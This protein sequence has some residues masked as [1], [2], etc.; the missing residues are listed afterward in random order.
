L[1]STDLKAPRHVLFSIPLLPRS[2]W[3]QVSS[4]AYVFSHNVRY[5]DSHPNKTTGKIILPYILIFIF[6]DNN[7][8]D[9]VLC[10]EW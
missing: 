6:L 5:Q 4:S 3:A 2:S 1:R 8:E 10:S 7:L 9:R